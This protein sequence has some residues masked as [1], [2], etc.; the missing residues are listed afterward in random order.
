MTCAKGINRV[1]PCCDGKPHD[2]FCKEDSPII[3]L[4][5]CWVR[6][7]SLQEAVTDKDWQ[8]LNY[9][10][11]TMFSGEQTIKDQAFAVSR[12]H[13][14]K[15]VPVQFYP[16]YEIPISLDMT[17]FFVMLEHKLRKLGWTDNY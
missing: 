8:Y 6:R 11:G 7:N 12:G 9:P 1:R 14:L 5:H 15:V 17:S 2:G 3:A 4:A 10:F 16:Y 13:G